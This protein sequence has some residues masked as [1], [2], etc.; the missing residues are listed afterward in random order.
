LQVFG[1][2]MQEEVHVGVD[3]AGKQRGV[4]EVDDSGAL[5]M[6]YRFADGAD[7]VALDENLAG[8]E[9]CASVDLEQAGGVEDDGDGSSG[10]RFLR[11][12]GSSNQAAKQQT[13][14]SKL[15]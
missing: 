10:R 14:F 13:T 12:R 2:G 5:R 9:E 1:S 15:A 4:A 11:E 8:L 6:V 7:A 3:E